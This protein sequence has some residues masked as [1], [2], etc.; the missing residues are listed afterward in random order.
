LLL[1]C[2]WR[3]ACRRDEQEAQ[4]KLQREWR[5]FTR[6]QRSSCVRLPGLGGDPSYVELLTCLEMAKQAGTPSNDDTPNGRVKR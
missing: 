1:R 3:R 5:Q 4:R 2:R 6:A